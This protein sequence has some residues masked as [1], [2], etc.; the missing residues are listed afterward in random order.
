MKLKSDGAQR[1]YSK[2]LEDLK[3]QLLQARD[4]LVQSQNKATELAKESKESMSLVKHL[5]SE[6]ESA[7]SSKGRLQAELDALHR[8]KQ[9]VS[10]QS[11]SLSQATR[12]QDQRIQDLQ[13]QLHR[14]K[15]EEQDFVRMSTQAEAR[16]SATQVT[17]ASLEHQ[18]SDLRSQNAILQAK[19]EMRPSKKNSEEGSEMRELVA[20]LEQE[21]RSERQA[22]NNKLEAL[23]SNLATKEIEALKA[24]VSA[25]QNNSQPV[26][27]QGRDNRHVGNQQSLKLPII[28]E[29]ESSDDGDD[30]ATLPRSSVPTI[31]PQTLKS[32]IPGE[33][34]KAHALVKEKTVPLFK[35]PLSVPEEKGSSTKRSR[36]TKIDNEKIEV[37]KV[38]TKNSSIKTDPPKEKLER[39]PSQ[40]RSKPVAQLTSAPSQMSIPETAST[41]KNATAVASHVAKLLNSPKKKAPEPKTKP[42]KQPAHAI[43]D[44]SVKVSVPQVEQAKPVQGTAAFIPKL[45]K[46]VLENENPIPNNR[47]IST[48]T[49]TKIHAAAPST[50]LGVSGIS[51]DSIA[52]KK[53]K[54]PT[55]DTATTTNASAPPIQT[56]TR[57]N[58][59]EL[60]GTSANAIPELMAAFNVNIP[61]RKK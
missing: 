7:K 30:E 17:I 35:A 47:S 4:G 5:Q 15:Q 31:R 33:Q 38:V 22:M 39:V 21:W 25:L 19:L 24:T 44:P 37:S 46:R 10:Q 28:R 41:K 36:K 8:D 12:H 9:Q 53:I 56:R 3:K 59:S 40:Y 20:R 42:S 55:R 13:A 60:T 2:Q 49:A 11:E 43:T 61:P 52:R 58:I 18:L 32:L 57:V 23:K 54:L 1:E 29:E 16:A 26:A 48:A 51:F 45:A 14:A 6:L 27:G 34:V 50:T